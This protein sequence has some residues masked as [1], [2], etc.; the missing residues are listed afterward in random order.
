MP[1]TFDLSIATET[2]KNAPFGI[3]VVDNNQQIIW[4][5][6]A[7]EEFLNIETDSLI[8][9]STN[10]ISLP[11][12]KSVLDL[13]DD[14][15]ITKSKRHGNRWLKC[16]HQALEIDNVIAGNTYFL[17][18]VSDHYRLQDEFK[19]IQNELETKSTRDT[20]TGLLNR[21][22]LAQVLDAQVSRSRRYN[23]PLSLIRMEVTGYKYSDGKPPHKDQILIAIGH[24]LNDQLRWADV[25]GRLDN[26]DFLLILPETE[27]DA[28]MKLVDKIKTSLEDIMV[29]RNEQKVL[30]EMC[31][32]VA[33][34]EK[35][36]D[37]GKLLGR[38]EHAMEAAK[39]HKEPLTA[40]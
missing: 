11:E 9:K 28:A 38:A 8:G 32:G 33:S 20:L 7:F 23:N 10:E 22:G 21:R 30:L 37:Q 26:E 16:W 40:G 34:W 1:E 2:L 24:L 29:G 14:I 31:F 3:L 27:N 4:T 13:N 5:N 19:R 6:K 17:I 35:G 12:F 36:D 18:D 39:N 15:V 25:S